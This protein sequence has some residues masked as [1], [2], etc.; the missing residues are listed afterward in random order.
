MIYKHTL[1]ADTKRTSLIESLLHF[2][3]VFKFTDGLNEVLN[4]SNGIDELLYCQ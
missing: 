4:I 2:F 3:K 1:P